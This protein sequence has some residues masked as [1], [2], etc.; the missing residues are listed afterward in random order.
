MT[1]CQ[2][3]AVMRSRGVCHDVC[4]T[5]GEGVG[6]GEEVR[7]TSYQCRAV[8]KS[9]GGLSR[10]LPHGGGGGGAVA[11]MYVDLSRGLV[12]A[13]FKRLTLRGEPC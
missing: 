3:C 11:G 8:L 2:C 10:C 12:S 7:V 4:H 1:S 6:C 9:R 13:S 5:V